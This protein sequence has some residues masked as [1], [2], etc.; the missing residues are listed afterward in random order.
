M[1]ELFGWQ[2]W[3]LRKLTPAE[4]RAGIDSLRAREEG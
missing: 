1:A 3:D 4:L 2:P